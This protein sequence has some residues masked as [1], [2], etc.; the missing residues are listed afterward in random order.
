LKLFSVMRA[1][2]IFPPSPTLSGPYDTQRH[3]SL[4]IPHYKLS[5][6]CLTM[7]RLQLFC[8]SSYSPTCIVTDVSVSALCKRWRCWLRHCTKSRKVAGSNSDGVT[9]F[10]IVIIF[11][12]ALWS[13]GKIRIFPGGKSDRYVGLTTLTPSCADCREI[14]DPPTSWEPHAL[15]R[16]A[17]G[18]LYLYLYVY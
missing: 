18:L 8:W 4:R 10:F 17:Q 12:V 13:W 7:K 2:G 6:T 16:A 15:S 11:Q 1:R 9:G 5:Q 3:S 14:W